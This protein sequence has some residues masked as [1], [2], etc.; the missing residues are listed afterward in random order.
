MTQTGRDR[1]NSLLFQG[2]GELVN[3]KF[4]PG[5]ARGLTVETLSGAAADMI[6]AAQDAWRR[7]VPS[8][9]PTTGMARRQLMG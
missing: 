1:L 9:P 6:S 5:N 8:A 4:F 7:G 3:V 2:E